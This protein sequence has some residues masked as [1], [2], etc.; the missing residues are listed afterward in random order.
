MSSDDKRVSQGVGKK[1]GLEGRGQGGGSNVPILQ[2]D[3]L[4]VNL[5][6]NDKEIKA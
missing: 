2:H 3:T 4:E 5:S 6:Q 1:W